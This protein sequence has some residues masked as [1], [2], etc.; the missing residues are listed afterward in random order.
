MRK[1]RYCLFLP[2]LLWQ[3][4]NP[5]E[6]TPSPKY[7]PDLAVFTGLAIPLGE[8][9]ETKTGAMGG[10][11]AVNGFN[12]EVRVGFPIKDQVVS[13]ILSSGLILNGM[14]TDQAELQDLQEVSKT[15]NVPFLSGISIKTPFGDQTDLY[16]L[17]RMGVNLFKPPT[18]QYKVYHAYIDAAHTDE[19]I[20]CV[21]SFVEDGKAFS[22]GFSAG[23]IFMK[24]IDASFNYLNL[25][26]YAVHG[27][28]KYSSPDFSVP[29][30]A[31]TWETAVS[32]I[33]LNLGFHF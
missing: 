21:D 19:T 12:G 30:A 13:F 15:W 11:F 16:M 6:E 29:E 20:R 2:L 3:A 18:F 26:R 24:R 28:E 27:R 14:N 7:K 4:A 17:G 31:I 33:N 8:F 1:M 23:L 25:G 5:G 22:L 32:L 10:G 9:A